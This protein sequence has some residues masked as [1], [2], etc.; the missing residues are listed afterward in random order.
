MTEIITED[1]G[2]KLALK[3]ASDCISE[4]PVM[5]LGSGASCAYGIR[6]MNELAQYLIV[7][8]T[9][10][11]DDSAIWE[12]VK[13]E[14]SKHSD[15]E[16]ALQK[17]SV[18]VDLHRQIVSWTRE[19]ILYDER[20]IYDKLLSGET[21]LGLS[22]L[23]RYL[24]RTTHKVVEV[25]TTNYDRLVEY[26]ACQAK[27]RYNTGFSEGALRHFQCQKSEINHYTRQA[28]FRCVDIWKVHGSIDWYQN[29][30]APPIGIFDHAVLPE[31]FEPLLVTPGVAKYSRTHQE[32]FRSVISFADSALSAARGFLCIGYGFSDDHI[33]PKLIQRSTE[34][35]PPI[36]ILA[37]T[38]RPG[39]K[40]FLSKHLH[41]NAV[42]FEK[43][44]TGTKAYTSLHPDGIA[45]PNEELW[46]LEGLLNKL[47]I[48]Q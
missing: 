8:V 4:V 15:L 16:E 3:I 48:Q 9:P 6:G 14:L 17:V 5:V 45:F 47:R 36:A 10:T 20:L 25:V 11:N 28:K 22:H 1:E 31:T 30:S 29:G 12:K 13:S 2:R 34:L 40:K 43:E 21:V 27:F 32:P 37:R 19:M 7:N 24:F 46:R 23:F 35:Q 42:A 18:S 41:S 39:A 38:L 33:E 44:G 26:A